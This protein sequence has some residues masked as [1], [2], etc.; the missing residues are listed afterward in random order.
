MAST[1][2]GR[3]LVYGGRGALGSTCVN[4]FKKNSWWVGNIDMSANE[5]A[6]ANVIVQAN[7]SWDDQ[8]DNVHSEV[9]KILNNEKVDAVI[10]VAGGWAGGN[11]SDKDFI[12]N[13]DL[14][15][16]QSVWTSTIASKIASSFLREGG[17]LQLT[18]A[19]PAID[20]GTPG[21]IGYGL[22][23]AAVHHL[24][25]SLAGEKSGLPADAL[26]VGILPVILDTPMNRKWMP[27]ADTST[28]TPLEFVSELLYKWS[29]KTE[30]PPNG[31]L[32]EIVTK[33]NQ[34]ELTNA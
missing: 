34:T 25:R 22:S 30:R 15:W 13:C 2:A 33:D 6:D 5:L 20:G 16:K 10:C 12:K 23:K 14:T 8:A 17:L 32:V 4:Y 11:S 28:W 9:A 18:G 31:S 1:T 24:V 27:K 7:Q 29:T 26:V 3:V 21:M 19:K